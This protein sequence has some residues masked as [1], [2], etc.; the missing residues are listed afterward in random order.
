MHIISAHSR[1]LQHAIYASL[2]PAAVCP[3][4]ISIVGV[5][6]ASV[7]CALHFTMSFLPIFNQAA[8][9][10]TRTASTSCVRFSFLP[11]LVAPAYPSLSLLSLPASLHSSSLLQ[12]ARFLSSI[13]SPQ[14]AFDAPLT[15]F[16]APRLTRPSRLSSPSAPLSTPHSSTA[17]DEA[18]GVYIPARRSPNRGR[19]SRPTSSRQPAVVSPS[20]SHSPAPTTST[21][22]APSES[23]GLSGGPSAVSPFSG[24]SLNPDDYPMDPRL[25]ESLRRSFRISAFFPIQATAYQP[26]VEGKD[27]LARSKTG[28]GKT[29]AFILPLLERLK[30]ERVVA[31]K[32]E[33]SVL[34]MEPTRELANQVTQEIEKLS[35]DT[36]VCAV[37]GGVGYGQQTDKLLRG[38]DVCVGTPGRL[39]DLLDKGACTLRETR[40][41]VLDE[42]DEMLRRGF[43]EDMEKIM[44]YASRQRKVQMLLFSATLPDWIQQV[45]RQFQSQPLLIDQVSGEDN[46]TPLQMEHV[47][48]PAPR[49]LVE[50]LKLIG[51][52]ARSVR[53]RVILFVNSKVDAD[54][55]CSSDFEDEL[56]VDARAL[57]GDVPQARRDRLMHSFKAGHFKMLVSLHKHPH[58]VVTHQRCSWKRMEGSAAMRR[59]YHA[60]QPMV[61][62]EETDGFPVS[63]TLA[64]AE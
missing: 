33:I 2:L 11:T 60:R 29:L 55:I 6:P 26:I 3:C 14:P 44:G 38:V 50:R 5:R 12:S 30:R 37:Y 49:L 61:A 9:S 16:D 4:L 21:A 13:A 43:K 35:S 42:A 57:H 40:V 25:R 20:S 46:S 58:T 51:E 54:V 52:L 24:G 39:M 28:T 27:V 45:S 15:E 59:L 64:R 48:L 63:F 22:S 23:T 32:G 18:D 17:A 47:A 41:V 62:V 56:G 1:Q 53:G 8:K 10:A 19:A 7:V 31:R 34:V 36:R